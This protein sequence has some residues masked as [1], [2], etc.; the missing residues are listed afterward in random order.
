MTAIKIHNSLDHLIYSLTIKENQKTFL[1]RETNNFYIELK[2]ISQYQMPYWS[3]IYL[4]TD[5]YKY[6]LKRFWYGGSFDRGIFIKNRFDVDIYF[7]YSENNNSYLGI[8]HPSRNFSLKE[9]KLTTN[10]LFELIYSNLKTFQ[11][12]HGLEMK[13]LRDPPY[14]HA[15]PIR[16]DFQGI[17]I[18]LDCIPAF[19]VFNEYL[20]IPNGLGGIK[21]INP[22]LEEQTLSK[23]N[24]M[25]NGKI[26][27]LILLIKYWNFTWGK[28]LKGYLIE[29]LGECIFDKIEIHTWDKAVKTFFSQAIHILDKKKRL[30]DRIYTQ[31]SILDEYSS[32]QLKYFL[33][34]LREAAIYVHKGDW[35]EVFDE[36]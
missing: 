2:N 35:T 28:P 9:K 23:L 1:R 33:E 22:S 25:Q 27:K 6:T 17:S 19:E 7:V 12:Y 29:R 20:V 15:I 3:N 26:I 11:Y 21:K 14:G 24:K 34:I 32:K 13:L 5:S 18:L 30:P 4:S 8:L 10:L 16:M 36:F 31:Y